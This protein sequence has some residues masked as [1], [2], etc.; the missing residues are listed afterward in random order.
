MSKIYNFDNLEYS[1]RHGMYGGMAGDK[2][3]VK[4]VNDFWII[5]YPK[6]TKDMVGNNLDAYTSSPLSEYIGSHIYEKLE[7]PVHETLLGVRNNKLVVACKDFCKVR[8]SLME[9]RTIK[10]AAHK[11][12]EEKLKTEMHYSQTR[13]LVNLNELLLHLDNNPILQKVPNIKER[14]WDMFVV[15]IFIDN[16]DR[17]NGN[18]GILCFEDKN[19]S[20]FYQ[21][22]PVYDNGNSFETKLSEEKICEL[23]NDRKEACIRAIGSRTAYTLNDKLVPAKKAL[24]IDNKD[25]RLAI[26]RIV[27]KIQKNMFEICD[28]I[29]DTPEKVTLSDGKEIIVCSN[30]R[31]NLYIHNLQDRLDNILIPALE[32]S[33]SIE[34]SINYSQS[35]DYE[36]D[37]IS[38]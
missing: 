17:N 34:N 28:L 13:D 5:K 8:G 37:D 2:D 19:G 33:I 12:L 31:K 23:L 29:Q 26:Q 4:I 1:S 24:F 32:N 16:N 10:N 3:G 11:E 38:L 6:N 18:W 27:P 25:L 20:P 21:L 30:N 7:I 22:A 15:D 9:M 36:P 35:Q 14:F